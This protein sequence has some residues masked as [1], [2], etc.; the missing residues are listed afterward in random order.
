MDGMTLQTLLGDPALAGTWALVPA[1]SSVRFTNKTMWGLIPV[2]GHFAEVTGQALVTGDGT[3]SGRLVIRADSVRTGLGMRDK[4]LRSADF[5]DTGSYPEIVVEVS[6]ADLD[7]TLSIRGTTLP[8]SLTT[9]ASRQ[10]D[11]TV[12]VTAR[13]QIDRTRWGVS[14][15]MV[16]MMPPTTTLVADAVF[17]M[18]QANSG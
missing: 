6:G 11:G 15:N 3:A 7:A 5:F 1:R 17:A 8:V 9:T 4:H 16:G 2:N 10:A 14:G 12:A 18:S 13:G